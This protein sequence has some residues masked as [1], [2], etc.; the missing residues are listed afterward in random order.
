MNVVDPTKPRLLLYKNKGKL[1]VSGYAH[2]ANAA[3]YF[4]WTH[5]MIFQLLQKP[6]YTA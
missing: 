2:I 6:I 3:T 5:F 4:K 1:S